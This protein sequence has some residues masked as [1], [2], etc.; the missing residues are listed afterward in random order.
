MRNPEEDYVEKDKMVQI[1]ARDLKEARIQLFRMYPKY[2]Y[3]T[4]EKIRIKN[5]R[6]SIYQFII[7]KRKRKSYKDRFRKK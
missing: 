2:Y 6:Q 5:N 3:V 1:L 4:V 7:R